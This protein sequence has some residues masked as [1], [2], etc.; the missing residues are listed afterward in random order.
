MRTLLQIRDFVTFFEIP[1]AWTLRYIVPYHLE[2]LHDKYSEV[3]DGKSL[4]LGAVS[5]ESIEA[6]H[7]VAKQYA[8]SMQPQNM[9]EQI[10][11][12]HAAS[13][14]AL[15]KENPSSCANYRL[16]L[17]SYVPASVEQGIV[18][19]CGLPFVSDGTACH[20]CSHKETQ[21]LKEAVTNG[22]VQ[23]AL[24]NVLLPCLLY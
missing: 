11:K 20:L 17:L 10:L 18:C 2:V 1:G 21:I 15:I 23:N 13:R 7:A 24:K 9:W 8:S 6:T 3:K 12:Y 5:T 19:H 22:S 16:A 4:G 14:L